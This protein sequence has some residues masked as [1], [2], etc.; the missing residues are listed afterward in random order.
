MGDDLELMV[1]AGCHLCDDALA[2]LRGA[3]L[4]PVLV[5]IDLD[6]GLLAEYDHRV[7]VLRRRSTGRVLAEGLIDEDAVRSLADC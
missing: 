5:D 4:V 1:R 7:P 2:A 3:G 6:P